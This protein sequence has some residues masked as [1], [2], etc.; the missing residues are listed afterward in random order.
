MAM[1]STSGPSNTTWTIVFSCWLV[2]SAAVLGSL[3]FS[4]VMDFTLCLLCWYQRIFWFPLV[5][6]FTAALFP[7][8]EKV[9]RYALPLALGGWMT[10]GYHNL[11][12]WGIVPESISPCS[13]GVS[14]TENYIEL[15][16]FVTI[17]LLS[18]LA[19]TAVMGL[20]LALKRRTTK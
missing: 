6:I 4:E 11:L 20:L 1:N 7:L 5:F 9:S 19:F 10:A 18:W 15:Y 13:Q 8:D 2:A 3:F 17:P 12:V 16:G 14:C